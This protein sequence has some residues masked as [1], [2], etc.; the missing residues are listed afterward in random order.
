MSD[1]I[2]VQSDV[3][4]DTPL[5]DIFS[6]PTYKCQEPSTCYCWWHSMTLKKIIG[7]EETLGFF[8]L[9]SQ[10]NEPLSCGNEMIFVLDLEMIE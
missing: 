5:C 1:L 3:L 4:I 7:K 2:E 9:L 8:I 6:E 10:E